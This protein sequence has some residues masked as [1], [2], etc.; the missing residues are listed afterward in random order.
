M[1]H[2][3]GRESLDPGLDIVVGP[4]RRPPLLGYPSL[5]R[6]YCARGLQ[7]PFLFAYEEQRAAYSHRMYSIIPVRIYLSLLSIIFFLRVCVVMSVARMA[8]LTARTLR[9]L[10]QQHFHVLYVFYFLAAG[11]TTTSVLIHFLLGD[12][13]THIPRTVYLIQREKERER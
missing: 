13:H 3:L 9:A 6:G 5:E 8:R 11:T 2:H 10:D 1:S 4:S 12:L 7:G